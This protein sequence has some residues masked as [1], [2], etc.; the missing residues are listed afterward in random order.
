MRSRVRLW[1]VSCVDGTIGLAAFTPIDV[2]TSDPF[3]ET[4]NISYR[5]SGSGR[6]WKPWS[7]ARET[8]RLPDPPA[9][10]VV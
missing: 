3:I 8:G 4:G 2:Y 7:P 10:E 9:S 5:D 1:Q 6:T